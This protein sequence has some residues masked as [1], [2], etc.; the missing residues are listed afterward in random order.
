MTKREKAELDYKKKMLKL[1]KEHEQAG[2]VE[3]VN[4]YFMPKDD[5]K[6]QDKYIEDKQEKG[7]NFEQRRWEEDHLNAAL[8]HFGAR[9][10]KDKKVPLLK[11]IIICRPGFSERKKNR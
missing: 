8:H 2:E 3:K 7:P 6:P 10:A 1:A 9:D 5:V 11:I 4:R